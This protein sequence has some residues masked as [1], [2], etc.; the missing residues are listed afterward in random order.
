MC[1]GIEISPV[2]TRVLMKS[3]GFNWNISSKDS[4]KPKSPGVRIQ[5]LMSWRTKQVPD[6]INRK[7]PKQSIEEVNG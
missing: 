3:V 7:C 2:E 4:N 6:Q 1:A 5:I